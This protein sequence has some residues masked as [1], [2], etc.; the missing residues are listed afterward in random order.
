MAVRQTKCKAAPFGLIQ[1]DG[2]GIIEGFPAI[3]GN[4]DADGDVILPGAFTRTIKGAGRKAILGLDHQ[5]PLGTTIELAEV[6]RNDLPRQILD[7]APDA[8]GGLWARGQVM[9]TPENIAHLDT[10]GRMTEAGNA[11]GMSFT[12]ATIAERKAKSRFGREV[13]ELVELALHEW[14]PDIRLRPRNAAARVTR[15][16]AGDEAG[17]E[18]APDAIDEAAAKAVAGS[19]EDLRDT[20]S[21]AIKASGRYTNATG[22]AG[23]YVDA[24]FSDRVLICAYGATQ[25][26]THYSVPYGFVDGAVVLGEPTEVDLV[27][28][29]TAK[30]AAERDDAEAEAA[31]L[32]Y[33]NRAATRLADARPAEAKA[34]AVLARVNLDDLDAAIDAL[35]RIRARAVKDTGDATGQG[36]GGDESPSAKATADEPT[37][38]L[39]ALAWELSI[40]S[41]EAALLAA[42]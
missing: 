4:V 29:V 37:A 28:V 7:A 16:K 22:T 25:S 11:P 23:F 5:V 39:D 14:G 40:L 38:D 30:A 36:T 33:I 21:D 24:T 10:I 13:N 8:T 42:K 1:Y 19:Y 15:A 32:A 20:V 3:F 18:P 41:S 6:G 2:D 34:G 26:E 9:L 27:T 12:Y 17:G 35:T 31:L